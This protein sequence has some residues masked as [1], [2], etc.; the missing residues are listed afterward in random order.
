MRQPELLLVLFNDIAKHDLIFLDI[1]YIKEGIMKRLGPVLAIISGI[2]TL[3][4]GILLFLASRG[5]FDMD[6]LGK[7][8][9]ENGANVIIKAANVGYGV[10]IGSGA[11]LLIIGIFAFRKPNG[12]FAFILLIIIALSITSTVL[13]AVKADSWPTA[14][15]IS[16][17][18]NG[19]AAFGLIT[20]F[21]R[22]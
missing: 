14:T 19:L 20:A 5:E 7:Y 6:F 8:V 15:I 17:V 2:T 10:M 12:F 4:F 1:I 18:I 16:L 3:V 22:S 21:T 11:L 9:D 13:G